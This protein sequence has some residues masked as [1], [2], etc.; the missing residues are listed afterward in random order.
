MLSICLFC[1]YRGVFVFIRFHNSYTY[2]VNSKPAQFLKKHIPPILLVAIALILVVQNY[3]PK[4]Y[5]SGWD[6]LHP[7]FNYRIYWSRILDGVWQEHQGLGAVGSQAHASEIPRVLTIMLF[8]LI[9]PTSMVR[10]TYAFFML[11]LG[12]L[13]L[14]YFMKKGVFSQHEPSAKIEISSFLAGLFYLLNL[15]TLQHFYVPLEMF[16][17]HYGYLGFFMLGLVKS[18]KV[19]SHKNL[20]FFALISFLMAPQAHTST[21]FFSLGVFVSAYVFLY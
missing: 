18:L 7:E 21:L 5:L 17:T 12:P 8:D 10:Y 4:T 9:L 3:T 15:V 16:L 6:T 14:Y 13:G 19:A 2:Y 1:L 11:V 20:A